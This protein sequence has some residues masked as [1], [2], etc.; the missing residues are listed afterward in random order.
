MLSSS[1]INSGATNYL[2]DR[3]SKKMTVAIPTTIT[4][5]HGHKIIFFV[6]VGD[7]FLVVFLLTDTWGTTLTGSFFDDEDACEDVLEADCDDDVDELPVDSD[8]A[9]VELADDDDAGSLF[10]PIL[11]RLLVSKTTP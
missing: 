9:L 7:A 2:R 4:N 11:G 6:F 5:S 3:L 8:V 1:H 10:S